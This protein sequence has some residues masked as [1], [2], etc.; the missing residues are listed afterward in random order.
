[1]EDFAMSPDGKPFEGA[2]RDILKRKEVTKMKRTGVFLLSFSLLGVALIAGT[3][4]NAF[5]AHP[6]PPPPEAA[7]LVCQVAAAPVTGIT[8]SN[9]SN[10]VASVP[11]SSGED[12]ATALAASKE[13][14]LVIRNVQPVNTSPISIVYI[15]VNG[16][17]DIAG[18][19]GGVPE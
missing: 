17:G 3:G 2:H 5:A 10:T 9:W 6:S 19:A 15:L 1:M 12:C 13:A 16:L 8:V 18:Q 14:G 7:V 4:N 11:I